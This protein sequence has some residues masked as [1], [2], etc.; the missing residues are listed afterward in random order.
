MKK[1]ALSNCAA[2][3]WGIA[4]FLLHVWWFIATAVCRKVEAVSGFGAALVALGIW[5]AVRPFFRKG[6]RRA[7]EEAAGREISPLLGFLSLPS[8]HEEREAQRPQARRDVIGD[9]VGLVLI[10]VGTLLNGSSAPIGRF[11]VRLFLS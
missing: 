8:Y 6:V 10:F 5:L 3:V 7:I 1:F 9:R 4:L 11:A 2:V